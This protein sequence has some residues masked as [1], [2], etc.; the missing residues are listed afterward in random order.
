MPSFCAAVNINTAERCTK[1]L[2]YRIAKHP[3]CSYHYDQIIN[4]K[5]NEYK[6]LVP[7]QCSMWY[8][9]IVENFDIERLTKGPI[10]NKK[11]FYKKNKK[12]KSNICVVDIKGKRCV[13]QKNSLC[14]VFCKY[15]QN[16]FIKNPLTIKITQQYLSNKILNTKLYPDSNIKLCE[17][18]KNIDKYN[19]IN[20]NKLLL[21]RLKK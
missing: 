17:Y 7:R 20:R 10:M 1:R 14:G 9:Y 4:E 12:C 11:Y 13:R 19:I 5:N 21:E 2:N 8:Q 6:I 15:H 16:L 18:I 3:F